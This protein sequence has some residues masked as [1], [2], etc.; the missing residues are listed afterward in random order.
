MTDTEV[1]FDVPPPP[2]AIAI[3]GLTLEPRLDGGVVHWS[4]PLS[5]MPLVHVW[6]E[7]FS[8]TFYVSVG[9]CDGA[10]VQSC[11]VSGP[12][13][14]DAERMWLEY[15]YLEAPRLCALVVDGMQPKAA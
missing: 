6:R 14:A 5:R 2:R 15:A 4:S 9:R 12:S 10:W 7:A 3:F 8:W 1:P 11:M 13:V